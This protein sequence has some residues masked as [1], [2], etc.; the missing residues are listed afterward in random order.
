MRTY[1]RAISH[2]VNEPPLP[3]DTARL[4][5]RWWR[6]TDADA[7]LA[8]SLWGDPRVNG[9]LGRSLRGASREQ[10]DARLALELTHAA[11][12][13]VQYWPVFKRCE[14][15][16]FV[17]VV[18]LRMHTDAQIELGFHVRPECWR[19]GYATEAGVAVLDFS[20]G[21]MRYAR[22]QAG[23]G[24]GN[25]ASR[26][27]IERLGFRYTHVDL[28]EGEPDLTYELSSKAWGHLRS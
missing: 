14:E 6:D 15:P 13:G 19:Q 11:E 4:R 18:G 17:G 24:A 8:F 12:R 3:C 23:H 16:S 27:T 20:F 7:R 2:R 9:S 25:D 10:T 5:F 22:I 21:T 28:F 1:R 26:R